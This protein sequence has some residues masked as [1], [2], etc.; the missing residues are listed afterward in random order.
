MYF[1]PCARNV[2]RRQ[3]LRGLSAAALG[4][5][6]YTFPW[7]SLIEPSALHAAPVPLDLKFKANWRG[8]KIGT[9]EIKVTPLDRENAWRTEVVIDMKVDLGLFGEISFRHE[10][11]EVWRGGR[12][13]ELDSKTDDDGSKFS[14]TGRAMGEQFAM[15]GPGGPRLVPGNLLT[16]SSAWSVEVCRQQQLIDVTHGD[17]IGLVTSP[18]GA[19]KI[20]TAQG[21]ETAQRYSIISPLIAGDLVYDSNGVWLGG[22]LERSGASIDY[23]L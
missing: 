1:S 21:M 7:N 3:V 6:A 23:V 13:V 9:H 15:K 20:D 8:D 16:S 12:L 11:V 19:T 17:V 2:P 10:C 22:R 4:T 5:A 18:K 14:V